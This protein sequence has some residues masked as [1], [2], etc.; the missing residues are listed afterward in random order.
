MKIEAVAAVYTSATAQASQ[1]DP[2]PGKVDLYGLEMLKYIPDIPRE[3]FTKM[4]HRN[5]MVQCI[6]SM[7]RLAPLFAPAGVRQALG[8]SK[9]ARK[10]HV[11]VK[12]GIRS[13]N[14]LS[15]IELNPRILR[16]GFL[17]I[18]K[19]SQKHYPPHNEGQGCGL[20]WGHGS[21]D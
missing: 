18:I 21:G 12:K 2:P 15:T 8:W 16:F 11:V 6:R 17:T 1:E 3:M 10:K 7:A 5:N 9:A 14:I 20:P 13:V 4:L 19:A